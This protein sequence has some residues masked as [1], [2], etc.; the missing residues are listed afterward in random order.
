MKVN[1]GGG[2]LIAS[3]AAIHVDVTT[4]KRTWSFRA[5]Q[6]CWR[7]RTNRSLPPNALMCYADAAPSK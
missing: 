4:W 5:T 2:V 6:I 7:G 3:A 1:D